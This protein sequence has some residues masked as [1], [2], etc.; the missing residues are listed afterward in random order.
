MPAVQAQCPNCSQS[1]SI[2][3]GL[4][5]KVARCRRCQQPFTLNP[6]GEGS[7]ADASDP[8]PSP[9]ERP[10]PD[11]LGR[12]VIRERIGA[13]A[14]GTVYRAY[15]P[16]LDREVALK[17]PQ[18][19][20]L[21]SPRAV[22]RFMREAKAAARL[23]HPHIVPIYD[24]GQDGDFHYIASAFIAGR[25]LQEA[26]ADGG[27]DLRQSAQVV[28]EMA[29]ALAYAHGLGIVHRDVKPANAMLDGEGRAHVMDFGLA[30]RLDSAENIT[31]D[32]VILGTP[33]YMAPE[34]AA[35]KVGA[36][37]PA[38]D[39]YSLGVVLHELLCGETPFSGPQQ[40]IL[41]NAQYVEPQKPRQRNP[42][43]P[44]D[45]ETICLKAMAKRPEDRYASCRDLADDLRRW[46]EGEPI[47]A[48][49]SGPVERAT[50]W[51]RRNAAVAG[52][53]ATVVVLMDGTIRLTYFAYQARRKTAE[54]MDLPTRVQRK[55][56]EEAARA[57]RADPDEER[58]RQL[59]EER[60]RQIKEEIL[61]KAQMIAK[62]T[63]PTEL[64]VSESGFFAQAARKAP[65]RSELR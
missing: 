19:G 7:R 5:G 52:L 45:L 24:A 3:S 15:D 31:L 32:G 41:F 43:V 17:V 16:V 25:T 10:I 65:R 36:P 58:T 23:R 9:N 49:R 61:Q 13:G 35:G 18:A 12:F 28:R 53:A 46:Q 14:F 26:I 30:H 1:Y 21:G 54:F 59:E 44:L 6:S 27:L 56:E 4:T 22:E 50:R 8:G 11:R 64:R 48:R 34:Q 63:F 51:A 2:D 33:A 55:T 40:V 29:E 20:T 47:P 42:K 37:L 60:T 57:R 39:Q 38:S 62:Q